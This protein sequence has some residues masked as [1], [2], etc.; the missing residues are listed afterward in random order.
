MANLRKI[1]L[2]AFPA[3]EIPAPLVHTFL[4]DSS[5]PINI[6]TWTLVGF[7]MEAN[8]EDLGVKNISFHTN[9]TD[10]AV[11][12]VWVAEDFFEPGKYETMFWIQN[13]PTTPTLRLASDL[14]VY[15]V[16]DAPGETPI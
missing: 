11:K 16:K 6:S 2:G 4:D 7:H 1:S 12:Y 5:S 9:G 15:E 13:H 10:G 14:I 3:G 8:G